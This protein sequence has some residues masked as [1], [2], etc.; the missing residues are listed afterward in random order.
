MNQFYERL[1]VIPI[2]FLLLFF[3]SGFIKN[4]CYSQVNLPSG[5]A[6]FSLPIFNWQ[7]DKSRLNSVIALNY[8]SGDGLKVNDVASNVGQGWNMIAGGSITRM[9]VGEPDDQIKKDGPVNDI[10]KYPAGYLTAVNSAEKGC[11]NAITNYPIYG[12]KNRLYKQ[13]NIIAEDREQDYFSFQF[14]GRSGM[15]VLDKAGTGVLLGDSK[16]KISFTQNGGMTCLGKKVRTTIA[17]FTITDENGSI[18]YF[19]RP[20]YTKILKTGYCDANLTEQLTQP[21]FKGGKV[22]YENAFDNDKVVDPYIINGWYLTQIQDGLTGRKILFDYTLRTINN[23]AGNDITYYFEN[24]YSIVSYKRSVTITPAITSIVFPDGHAATFNYSGSTRV[25]LNG[26]YALAS[27]D[28]K[29]N[30]RYLSRYLLNTSYFILNRYGTPSSPYEKKCARLCLLSVKRSGV[31]LKAEEAP[32]LFDYYLGSGTGY[33]FVPP[34]F[35]HLKD[36]W[37]YY[38]GNLSKPYSSNYKGI[39]LTDPLSSLDNNQLMGLCFLSETSSSIVLN[40]KPGYAKNGLLKQI[41]YPTGGA[42]T[43]EYAQNTAVLSGSAT[44]VGGVHVSATKST[45]GG[46]S[47]SCANPLITQYNYVLAS[48]QTSRW[49]VE[50]PKN[51]IVMKNHYEP[52]KKYWY[53]KPFL[54]TCGYRFQYPG[55]LS[56]ESAMNLT[57]FQQFMAAFS[58]V[59][60]AAST[61][62]QVIDIISWIATPS[63]PV[64][65]VIID[66]IGNLLDLGIGC[67]LNRSQD[68]TVTVFYNSDLNSVNPLPAQFK[69]VEVIQSTG[70]AGKIAYQFTSEDDYPVWE[71]KNEIY[72]MKQRYAYWAY[73]LPRFTTVFDVTGT[74]KVKETEYIYD[75]VNARRNYKPLKSIALL[76]PSCKSQ[77]QKSSSQPNTFWENPDLTL[78]T[79][80]LTSNADLK[81]EIYYAL[82]GRMELKETRER[83]YELSDQNQ[84]AETKTTYT[85]SFDNYQVRQVAATQSNGDINYKTIR[86]N[87]DSYYSYL[88]YSSTGEFNTLFKNNI[89]NIPVETLTSVSKDNGQTQ[90]I[91]TDKVSEFTTVANGDIRTSR[92]LEQRFSQPVASI[93]YYDGPNSTNNPPYKEVQTF[94]YDPNPLSSSLIGM[95][96]EGNHVVSNIYDYDYKYVVASV[97]NAE[98]LL[99]K[100]AYTSFE[101]QGSQ[102]GG[103]T[104]NGATPASYASTSAV[105]GNSSFILSSTTSVTAPASLNA[106]KP[107]KLSFWASNSSVIVSG[108]SKLIKSAPT[109][110]GYTYYEYDIA[111][112]VTAITVSGAA[113]I[114]ELRLYPGTARMRT[115]SYDPL[116]G[117]TAE[118]DENNRITYYEYD[119]LARLRFIKD[120]NKHVVKMYEYNY[121]KQ[122]GCP[123]TYSNLAV[124]EIFT[125]NNCA[126]GYI[127]SDITYTVP[128]GKYTSSISQADADQKVQD[129]LNTN[130][131]VYANS[132]LSY[133]NTTGVGSCIKL[134]YNSGKSQSFTKENC[135]PGS[136]G[137]TMTY[138]VPA[139]K[140]FSTLNQ[141]S[142]D[143]IALDEINAN[144]QSVANMS[145]SCVSDSNPVWEA[146]EGALTRCQK[147]ANDNSTGRLDVWMTDVNPGSSSYRSSKWLDGG[148]DEGTCPPTAGSP[149]SLSSQGSSTVTTSGVI[150]GEPGT[151]ITL[152]IKLLSNDPNA[153]LNGNVGG[154]VSLSGIGN[155]TNTYPN[156][157]VVNT[158]QMPDVGYISWKLTI[159]GTLSSGGYISSSI[160]K[161]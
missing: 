152:T 2:K 53:W 117:K 70:G 33:D 122:S 13:H 62:M 156:S 20:S 96:D 151:K 150:T 21:K 23:A 59:V 5:S 129:E 86:Y 103:W 115:V 6:T 160:T 51:S 153:T 125:K 109:I 38:N 112:G 58:T 90:L 145:G 66:V 140:Y 7:D 102:L 65:A 56:A 110:N 130:G 99:D 29:Y 155:G 95:K 19:A 16:L 159:S 69:R 83:V 141:A 39:P 137:T 81:S 88:N 91:L 10:T 100:P 17:T 161:Q 157:I 116:I 139:G 78:F 28:I 101:T 12:E 131:Q 97:I 142:A 146:E 77:I 37:G 14:N 15:F 105:T 126:A 123:V 94:T 76:Y 47:N 135:P 64:G 72:S 60:S 147:D 98:P 34:P 134:W 52:V 74:K 79:T 80:D 127:G 89:L 1:K 82:T 4:N 18:Y 75:T 61:V 50:P 24:N 107:Y 93:K 3:I 84:I 154:N 118:C 22:Y 25:D 42:L 71:P 85:Y 26:D 87:G 9:Q 8:S 92:I 27:V 68:N 63:G 132:G 119:N 67:L 138:T 46:Y 133:T 120:E 41:I 55:I 49:G 57:G 44:D 136:I 124:S 108:S 148:R 106:N 149:P 11:L 40:P 114:D 31:D 35:F 121:A 143:S 158:I 111:K 30:N 45:D 128:A 48:G 104:I 43:Y 54:G 36:I 32:Y 73:G 144:G 113:N